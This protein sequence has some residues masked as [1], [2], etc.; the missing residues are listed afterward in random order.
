MRLP[1]TAQACRAFLRQ[2]AGRRSGGCLMNG[3][4]RQQWLFFGSS[5]FPLHRHV[6]SQ[7]VRVGVERT[8]GGDW[9]SRRW[10]S[11]GGRATPVL[12]LR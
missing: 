7:A 10:V 2:R 6:D 3:L 11:Q 5:P 8:G 4:H 12:S 1:P 9:K